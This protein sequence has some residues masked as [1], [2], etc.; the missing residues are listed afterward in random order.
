MNPNWNKGAFRACIVLA[1]LWVIGMGAYQYQ[2]ANDA[3][4]NSMT[5]S[6]NKDTA[7]RIDASG[8]KKEDESAQMKNIAML[9][10]PALLLLLVVPIGG[11]ITGGFKP[12]GK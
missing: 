4:N 5:I 8:I 7:L 2:M 6:I 10:L 3:E 9:L 12:E 1:V 11:W